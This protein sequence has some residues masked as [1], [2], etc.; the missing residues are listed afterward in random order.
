MTD[1]LFF[2][3]KTSRCRIIARN[4]L[5]AI[6]GLG[7]LF[8]GISV[9]ALDYVFPGNLPV[10]CVENSV[11]NYSCGSLSLAAG[12]TLTVSTSNPITISINGALS[13]GAGV[14]L[15]AS[16][17]ATNLLLIING[18]FTLGANSSMNASVR[19]VGAGAITLGAG[20]LVSGSLSTESGDVGVGASTNLSGSINTVTGFVTLGDGSLVTSSITT[21]QNG[22]VVVG[23]SA[24]VG[25]D[26]KINGG[27]YV[28]LGDSARVGGSI[29]TVSDAVTMGANS[30]VGGSISV[31]ELGAVTLGASSQVS[32]N[33]TTQVGAV[34]VGASSRVEGQ[35]SINGS[36]DITLGAGSVV[37]AVCCKGSN[38]SCVDGSN[39]SSPPKQCVSSTAVNFECME[40]GAIY[41][42][43]IANPVLRNPLY[44]K[45][46][47]VPF[48]FDIV[49]INSDGS[50]A[51]QFK[52]GDGASVK[53]ELVDGNGATSCANRTVLNQ[54]NTRQLNFS[55]SDAGRRKVDISADYTHANLR[56]R[57]T[58]ATQS[59]N[60]VGCSSDNFS[61]RPSA[62]TLVS[63]ASANAPGA[64][65]LPV[66]G[67][68]TGFA[69]HAAT[70]SQ[71]SNGYIGSLKLDS[72]KLR[73]QTSMQDVTI[74]IGGV[75]GNLTPTTLV[76]NEVN[77]VGNYSDVG[78]LYL[79]P[80]AYRDDMLT[81][82]DS[83][84][85]DCLNETANDQYLSTTLINGKYGCSVGNQTNVTL[86]R[87]APDHFIV[88]LP[89]LTAA[90]SVG[91]AFSYFGQDGFDTSFT[92]T[93]MNAS[94]NTTRN[95]SGVFAHF[96]L[97]NY[98][99][100]GFRTSILPAGAILSSGRT[101]PTGTWGQGVAKV[102]AHHQ[103][104][105]PT[106]AVPETLVVISASPSDNET[107]S[108]TNV[109][110]DKVLLRYGRLQMKNVYGSEMLPLPVPLE[111]QYWAAGGY[112]VTNRDDSCTVIS[113]TSFVMTNYTKQLKPCNTYLSTSNGGVFREGKL[114]DP[115][116]VLS[117]PGT[118]NSGS[119][120]L[121]LNLTANAY[122]MV[123]VQA[124]DSP[125]TAANLPWF[126]VNPVARATFGI[127]KSKLIYSRENY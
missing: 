99:G 13:T 100:Y 50:I 20:A 83:N 71:T 119:V 96:D 21:L 91:V 56:C 126:G 95:Y 53:L 9:Q 18:A 75:V 1:N 116:L 19:T 35:I 113:T 109:V 49:A 44:T 106:A 98:S 86:G 97:T 118:Q 10:G 47:G 65:S 48:S 43:V 7:I 120:D 103:I 60:V 101:A 59:P 122:G 121:H 81:L 58:D 82:V 93:A 24:Q 125:A 68:G 17:A 46:T 87:F 105:R 76:A 123:C 40:S 92:L 78:Y 64:N 45:L 79:A 5:R 30:T 61:I 110:S 67:A 88:S 38:A 84:N 114:P 6:V 25:G 102:A 4:S 74:K 73:A 77:V 32:G 63:S 89:K 14:S 90:C 16:G 57:I 104:S 80:G 51:T 52:T 12:D 3:M 94:G 85:G 107:S 62:V 39:V 124:T 27:G 55:T 22:Y 33:I 112:Y 70:L 2:L 42:N 127:Y 26:I 54:Q 28:T 29:S 11:G 117:R 69:L 36:G 8:G 15:N 31:S 111:A 72:A 108:K 66:I 115:G 34:T 41:N 23:V 37:Y